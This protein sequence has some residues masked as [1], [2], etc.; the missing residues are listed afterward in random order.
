MWSIML[1]PLLHGTPLLGWLVFSVRRMCFPV[2]GLPAHLNFNLNSDYNGSLH[3]IFT[4]IITCS[5][6]MIMQKL[7]VSL[8][9]PRNRLFFHVFLMIPPGSLGH[10]WSPRRLLPGLGSR[11][12]TSEDDVVPL[13]WPYWFD[14]GS[15]YDNV[16]YVFIIYSI[17]H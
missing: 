13:W 3:T 7:S 8:E 9:F 14:G 1:C 4:S 12:G 16:C 11:Q 15:I 6:D 17:Y 2:C 10:Q 5:Q